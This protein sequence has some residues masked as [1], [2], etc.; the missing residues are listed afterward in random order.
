MRRV[1]GRRVRRGASRPRIGG[2]PPPLDR[3]AR[4]RLP[5]GEGAQG[6][7]PPAGRCPAALHRGARRGEGE[8]QDRGARGPPRQGRRAAHRRRDGEHLPGSAGARHAPQPRRGRQASAGPQPA[9]QS[10]GARCG[11]ALAGRC[12]DGAGSRGDPRDRA[13]R[14]RPRRG[15]D[16]ARRRPRHHRALRRAHPQSGVG[17]LERADGAL[18][19]PGVRGGHARDR[20]GDGQVSGLHRSR[21][22]G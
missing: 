8:R 21:R 7:Q 5:D 2:R 13:G 10:G 11:S 16:G 1:R 3:R 9:Q 20:V 14:R 18:R 15:G 12:V 4:A 6:A 22:R 19:E 17:I